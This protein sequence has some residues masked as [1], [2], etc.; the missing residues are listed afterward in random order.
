MTNI[1]QALYHLD[2][3]DPAKS[4]KVGKPFRFNGRDMR[5]D[6][7]FDRSIAST[8]TMRQLYEQRRL[9]VDET[10]VADDQSSPCAPIALKHVGHGKYRVYRGEEAVS[11]ALTK[12]EAEALHAKLAA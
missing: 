9:V 2:R 12:D 5:P 6:E 3:F 10:P 4:F 11:E 1:R 7:P 8:R